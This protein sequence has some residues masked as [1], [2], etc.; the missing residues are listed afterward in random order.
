MNQWLENLREFDRAYFSFNP[1]MKCQVDTGKILPILMLRADL[2]EEEAKEVSRAFGNMNKREV[3]KE[4]ADLIYV[5]VGAASWLDIDIEKVFKRVHESNLTKFGEGA[6]LRVD[7]K[8]L[9]SYNYIA[10]DLA[11]IGEEF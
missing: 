6:Q 1:E 2:I 7:G 3:A 10:P 9:K 4:L 5:C 11:F 8:I